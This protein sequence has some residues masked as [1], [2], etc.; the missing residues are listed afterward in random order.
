MMKLEDYGRRLALA[1]GYL[2]RSIGINPEPFMDRVNVIRGMIHGDKLLANL[3]HGVH[4]PFALPQMDIG[5][6]GTAAE[7]FLPAVGKAYRNH[8]AGRR[9]SSALQG[10]LAEQMVPLECS[11]ITVLLAK[12]VFGPVV[13]LYFPV[14][15]QG[16]SPLA[17]IE[18]LSPEFLDR[19][20]SSL[21]MPPPFF[22]GGV[23]LAGV[24]ETAMALI[25]YPDVL[26]RDGQTPRLLCPAVTWQGYLPCFRAYDD[27]LVFDAGVGNEGGGYS[28]GLVVL[29]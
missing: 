8:F 26:A 21:E 14:S 25:M 10:K 19:A 6:Y 24:L 20:Q 15:L 11:W 3:L 29:G 16:Y 27:E 9:F 17:C 13:G 2:G 22:P 12:M 7:E 4:L 5:N 28:G 18:Q 23:Q 1:A